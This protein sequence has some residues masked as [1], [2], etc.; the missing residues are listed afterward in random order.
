MS[1]EKEPHPALVAAIQIGIICV[2]VFVVTFITY[3]TYKVMML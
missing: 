1:S 2:T 3:M